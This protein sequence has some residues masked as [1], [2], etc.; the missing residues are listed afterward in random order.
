Q[1]LE[2]EIAEGGYAGRPLDKTLILEFHRRI[3]GELVP[4]IAG[5]W[6]HV[7]VRVSD[8]EAPPYP[9]VPLL[10]QEYCRDL[11]ARVSGLAGA[12]DDRLLELL[13]FA[14][15][16]LL[17]VHPFEDFNGRVTRV[18]LA[19]LLQRLGLPAVDPTPEPGEETSRYLKA[20][21]AADH[22]QWKPLME[23]W[24]VRFEKEESP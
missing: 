11:D 7:N 21:K 19:E 5:H 10:M 16:R 24:R 23:F 20:L 17:W 2:T 6:R 14:E 4:A 22:T 12:L 8:H 18:L 9:Q 3:C 15:G 1:R 13:A